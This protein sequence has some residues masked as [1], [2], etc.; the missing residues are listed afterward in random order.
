MAIVCDGNNK[1]TLTTIVNEVNTHGGEID[2]HLNDTVDAHDASAISNAPSGNL[3]ATT[4]QDALDELQSELNAQVDNVPTVLSNGTASTTVV[5]ITSDGGT[6]DLVLTS[7]SATKSGI[8]TK[9]SFDEIV[10]NSEHSASDHAPSTAEQNVQSDWTEG[11]TGADSY[12]LNKE[13]IAYTTAIPSITATVG[14]LLDNADAVKFESIE[15]GAEVNVAETYTQHEAITEAADISPVARVYI[16]EITVDNN[17]HV[18]AVGVASAEVDQTTITGNA[19]TA[20]EL[21]T[22]RTFDIT[23]DMT[24]TGVSFNGAA[25]V[26]LS[27]TINADAVTYTKIQNVVTANTLLGSTVAGGVVTELTKANI[28][29]LLNVEDGA[30][31]YAHPTHDGDDLA[32]S[33]TALTGATVVSELNFNVTTDTFGHVTDAT[34]TTLATRD[35]TI[36]DLG[37]TASI[38]EVDYTTGVTSAI[39]TQLDEKLGKTTTD[40]KTAG[41]LTLDDNV[42]LYLGTGQ[43]WQFFN[44]GVH[45]Y[46]DLEA[47]IGNFYIRDGA[48]TRFTF[49]DAGHFTATGNV[50]AYSDIKLKNNIEVIPNAMDK[51]LQLSGYTFDRIDEPELGRQTGVIAQELQAVLPEAVS[52][53]EHPDTGEETLTVAYGNVIGL[54][55]EGMKELQAE[56]ELLKVK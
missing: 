13:T 6:D 54:L 43:D 49:D 2:S 34:L 18:T 28:L 9:A 53:W 44:N 52:I 1:I 36:G 48:T 8:L 38:T 40:I 26:T 19:G 46:M 56:I 10:V 27:P 37:V 39:Q 42:Y 31:N 4:V 12:I 22:A 29:S 17:G 23:G 30:T 11:N 33:T 24:T 50:T 3:V 14:G 55:I 45:A 15:S 7:A 20:T 25:N 35:M 32:V 21:E 16:D 5:N 41:S 51:I 47:G